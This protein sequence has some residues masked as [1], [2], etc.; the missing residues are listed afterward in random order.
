MY[1]RG[2]SG[3]YFIKRVL[4][5]FLDVQYFL[6]FKAKNRIGSYPH[7]TEKTRLVNLIEKENDKKKLFLS[8]SVS[9]YKYNL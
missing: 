5:Q 1:S 7:R 6:R 3:S 9:E 8:H 4:Q 2:N